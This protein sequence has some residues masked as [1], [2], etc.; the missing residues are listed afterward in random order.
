MYIDYSSL[1]QLAFEARSQA[2][3]QYSD[4][5]VGA[6]LLCADG[7]V[8]TGCNIECGAFSATIC[9][10]RVAIFKA[11][12]EGENDFTAIA[13]VGGR[14]DDDFPEFCPPCG[15]CRQVIAEYCNQPDFEIILAK[16]TDDYIVYTVEQLLPEAF[17]GKM[18]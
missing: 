17:T 7:E 12:S 11:I 14:T 3:A 8:Y 9:A 15:I 1:I 10:E 13:I 6:A 18:L 4:F 2:R 5:T 16:N